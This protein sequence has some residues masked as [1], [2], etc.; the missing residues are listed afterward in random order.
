MFFFPAPI[1][2]L[3]DDVPN[4]TNN[5]SINEADKTQ[6]WDVLESVPIWDDPPLKYD[7]D[8]REVPITNP[9]SDSPPHDDHINDEV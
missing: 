4:N 3:V 5:R 9:V 8:T 6:N 1:K 2:Q 7:Q